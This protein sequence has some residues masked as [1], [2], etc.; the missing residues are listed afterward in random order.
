MFFLFFFMV[1]A[2]AAIPYKTM[3]AT[4]LCFQFDTLMLQI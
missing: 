2:R 3:R 1:K 4:H